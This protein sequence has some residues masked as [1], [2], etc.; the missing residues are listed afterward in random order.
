[1]PFPQLVGTCTNPW[2]YPSIYMNGTRGINPVPMMNGGYCMGVLDAVARGE[3]AIILIG[4][5]VAFLWLMK[6]TMKQQSEREERLLEANKGWQE[7]FDQLSASLSGL[8][9][10]IKDK[11]PNKQQG[12]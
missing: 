9:G 2:T 1:M 10:M 12:A 6:F 11:C 8:S 7:S 3:L 5:P 4:W